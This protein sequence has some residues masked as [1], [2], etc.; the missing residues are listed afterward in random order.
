[1]EEYKIISKHMIK[2]ISTIVKRIY[3][4]LVLS[5][6]SLG[7]AVR[8][9]RRVHR[10]VESGYSRT[11]WFILDPKFVLT[12]G[13]IC[14]LLFGLVLLYRYHCIKKRNAHAI[15]IMEDEVIVEPI[16]GEQVMIPFNNIEVLETVRDGKKIILK[17]ND[18]KY[19]FHASE[20]TEFPVL[21]KQLCEHI[22]IQ[23][24]I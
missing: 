2:P 6:F 24:N 5:F 20:I 10:M 13:W 21:L 11:Q 9:V 16:F 8:F 3:F 18:I 22:N 17:T 14:L 12:M 4:I 7:I 19:I 1:M 23:K 15:Y